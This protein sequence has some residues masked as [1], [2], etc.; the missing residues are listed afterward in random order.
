TVA[1]LT[2][3]K[4]ALTIFPE[5]TI[6]IAPSGQGYRVRWTITL[7][8]RGDPNGNPVYNGYEYAWLSAYLPEG[9]RL[10]ST[11]RTPSSGD[12][13]GDPRSR[14]FGIGIMPGTTVQTTLDFEMPGTDQILLR[15]QPGFNDLAVRITGTTASCPIDWSLTLTEDMLVDLDTCV[16][17]PA[18]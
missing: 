8:H 10:V 12:L 7:D 2:G 1:G 18:E 3:G 11:S 14:S 13:A 6:E 5:A 15:R 9:A 4:K 16:A 17:V